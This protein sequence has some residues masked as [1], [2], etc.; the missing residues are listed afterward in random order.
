MVFNAAKGGGSERN[1]IEL[2]PLP[3]RR[4]GCLSAAPSGRLRSA[5]GDRVR[6]R[7]RKPSWGC[8]RLFRPILV[9]R[10]GH[11]SRLGV[12]H[13]HGD[14]QRLRLGRLPGQLDGLPPPAC[15]STLSTQSVS[16]PSKCKMSSR[17]TTSA[18]W[19]AA[20]RVQPPGWDESRWNCGPV[21]SSKP[22]FPR[23]TPVSS[24][25]GSEGAGS[26]EGQAAFRGI[27]RHRQI[28]AAFCRRGPRCAT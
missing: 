4:D 2:R 21:Q 18:D 22:H 10:H 5:S 7:R 20:A 9:D 26:F 16:C 15:S 25:A 3:L 28:D 6:P 12:F 8:F 27:G 13:G 14:F 1:A 19:S 23:I 24:P 11:R 17:P